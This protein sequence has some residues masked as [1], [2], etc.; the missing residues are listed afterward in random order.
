MADMAS[1]MRVKEDE[2]D[3]MVRPLTNH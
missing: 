2:D 1:E 3:R